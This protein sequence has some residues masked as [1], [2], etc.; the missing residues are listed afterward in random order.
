[1][2]SKRPLTAI[3][4]IVMLCLMFAPA[5]TLVNAAPGPQPTILATWTI[6]NESWLDDATWFNPADGDD[7]IINSGGI[8]HMPWNWSG[9][10]AGTLV[11]FDGITVN[12][13]GVFIQHNGTTCL[14]KD[15]FPITINEGGQWQ[16]LGEAS[17]RCAITGSNVATAAHYIYSPTGRFY[18][19]YT[20]ISGFYR[21]IYG[22]LG[23]SIEM[24]SCTVNGQ[25]NEGVAI[26][27]SDFLAVNTTISSGG[28]DYVLSLTTTTSTVA[29]LIDCAL[30]SN[31]DNRLVKANYLVKVTF[32]GCT[33]QG[34][35][36]GTDDFP[37]T[38]SNHDIRIYESSTVTE[39][40]GLSGVA[41]SPSHPDL[42]NGFL[43]DDT[44]HLYIPGFLSYSPTNTTGASTLFLANWTA[45]WPSGTAVADRVALMQNW[46]HGA[47]A[48]AGHNQQWNL[49][50]SRW[51][52]VTDCADVW[53]GTN[54]TVTLTAVNPSAMNYHTNT[55]T[56]A[57]VPQS[58][59]GPEGQLYFNG[60]FNSTADITDLWVNASVYD[61]ATDT[62]QR[63]L[64]SD[65]S[66][67]IIQDIEYN[68]TTEFNSNN[69]IYINATDYNLGEYYIKTVFNKT[70]TVN[71]LTSY[72]QFNVEDPCVFIEPYFLDGAGNFDS[73]MGTNDTI[74]PEATISLS[75]T[76]S[77]VWV[78]AS[79]V[80][81][82]DV[83]VTTLVNEA[84]SFTEDIQQSLSTD[85]FGGAITWGSTGHSPG[86]YYIDIIVNKTGI[87]A[88]TTSICPFTIVNSSA[89]L[90]LTTHDTSP[91]TPGN[92]A[93]NYS[94]GQTM[95]FDGDI[96]LSQN[97]SNA[98]VQ[99]N[100]YD[101]PGAPV[102][103]FTDIYNFTK[104]TPVTIA[105]ISGGIPS[106]ALNY[107]PGTYRAILNVSEP[108]QI[109]TQWYNYTVYFK[110]D[111]NITHLAS[112]N[113]TTFNTDN[114]SMQYRDTDFIIG[115]IVYFNGTILIETYD[116][117]N[118]QLNITI[119]NQT[120]YIGTLLNTTIT[121][122]ASIPL[123]L[124]ETNGGYVLNWTANRTGQLYAMI[125]IYKGGNISYSNVTE[126]FLV[127]A[128][129]VVFIGGG[130]GIPA[131]VYE[132]TPF[133]TGAQGFTLML[134]DNAFQ[135]VII[136][137]GMLFFVW[138]A[139]QSQRGKKARG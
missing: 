52:Y 12:V 28:T 105:T 72:A 110:I 4:A 31:T 117:I 135:W 65:T 40:N 96:Q 126:D 87:V 69:P 94:Y 108:N 106:T 47:D 81:S 102:S 130:G 129:P 132:L 34:V 43:Y 83:W 13:G 68:M 29:T 33:Y 123:N 138:M 38:T 49:T 120:E 88:P 139:R 104:E 113:I 54:A 103:V 59:I 115:D 116:V 53:S 9:S 51:G 57:N 41:V 121:L 17:S 97:V 30:T 14:I 114:T 91:P 93:V 5:V 42:I 90:N 48:E 127:N 11:G 61:S 63:D 79:I 8:V 95:Y 55:T 75:E 19:Q 36:I 62:W 26:K 122:S 101:V 32:A 23:A 118:V 39:T 84:H 119:H 128:V 70:D 109:E 46:S 100:L 133:E 124:T 27:D 92:T 10:Q 131:P 74:W 73:V 58:N 56:A 6:A 18:A 86:T 80:D 37:V 45:F 71:N 112:A 76:V 89:Q 82:S 35:A 20:D 134:S 136:A 107:P 50:A 98:S 137:I 125:S 44:N 85:I 99:L 24:H 60:T 67:S 1:M 21:G 16:S 15:T 22:A 25:G 78:N 111:S 3:L 66:I 77:D 7:L 64:I 2:P